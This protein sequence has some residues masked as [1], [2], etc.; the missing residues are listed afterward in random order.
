MFT[1]TTSSLCSVFAFPLVASGYFV[2][3]CRLRSS[4]RCC[5]GVSK[6]MFHVDT[7]VNASR[8]MSYRCDQVTSFELHAKLLWV[9]ISFFLDTYPWH[10]NVQRRRSRLRR[11][12]FFPPS[13]LLSTFLCVGPIHWASIAPLLPDRHLPCTI[14]SATW[15]AFFYSSVAAIGRLALMS[16]LGCRYDLENR[17]S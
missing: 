5:T 4:P 8:S 6:C 16:S 10:Q 3:H 13:R 14:V 1:A 9:V 12:A 11:L 15:F 2:V 7:S 17:Q